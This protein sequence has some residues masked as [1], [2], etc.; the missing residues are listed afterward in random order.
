MSGLVAFSIVCVLFPF[1]NWITGPIED[2]SDLELF[3]G[4]G[5]NSTG[6]VIKFD[7]CGNKLNGE[8]SENL[9]NE[10]S[11]VRIPVRVWAWLIFVLTAW[12]IAR[13]VP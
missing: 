4:S 1:S 11:V 3:G 2:D 12:I 8:D 13:L 9:V 7:F 6:E 5:L 10:N